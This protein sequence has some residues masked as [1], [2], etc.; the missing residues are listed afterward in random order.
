MGLGKE[1][2]LGEIPGWPLTSVWRGVART[3]EACGPVPEG[4]DALKVPAGVLHFFEEMC[5]EHCGKE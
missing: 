2:F 1:A 4:G 5:I 3:L